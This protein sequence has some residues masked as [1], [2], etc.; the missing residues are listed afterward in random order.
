MKNS[1]GPSLLSSEHPKEIQSLEHRGSAIH[2]A[3]L[4]ACLQMIPHPALSHR[5]EGTGWNDDD[6]RKPDLS[7]RRKAVLVIDRQRP[8]NSHQSFGIGALMVIKTQR[9]FNL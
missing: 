6:Y 7:A 9:H 2:C 5:V 1:V 8:Q 4:D 3:F